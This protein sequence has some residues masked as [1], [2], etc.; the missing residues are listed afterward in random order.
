MNKSIIIPVFIT[1]FQI[2]SF[3]HL[4]YTHKYG[5]AQLP[6]DF[7]ELNLIAFCDV[8]VLIMAYILYFTVKNKEILWLAPISL[9]LIT[10]VALIVIYLVSLYYKWFT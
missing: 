1:I 2:I 7:I 3:M 4:F 10:I 5:S 9:A 6:A 8:I